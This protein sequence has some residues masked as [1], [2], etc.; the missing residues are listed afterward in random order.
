MSDAA[1]IEVADAATGKISAGFA[2][3]RFPGLLIDSLERSYADWEDKLETPCTRIDVVPV[4][5]EDTTVLSRTSVLYLCRVDV[6]VRRKF[7]QQNRGTDG[8]LDKA[9]ID[10]LVLF[11]QELHELFIPQPYNTA[12]EEASGMLPALPGSVWK[13][14]QLV[15]TYDRE[16]LRDL[17]TFFGFLSL[18][19]EVRKKIVLT[20]PLP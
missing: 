19:F 8:R 9:A 12:L 16:K 14:T 6:G 11:M 3:D 10:R 13:S 7:D 20:T 2:A 4:A 15:K 17:S 5:V 18:R 1:L